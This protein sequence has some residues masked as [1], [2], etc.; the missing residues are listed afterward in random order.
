MSVLFVQ[1]CYYPFR[2]MTPGDTFD[3]PTELC[4]KPLSLVGLAGLDTQNNAVHKII[5]D[6]FSNNRRPDRAPVQFKLLDA[7]CE[8]APLK[9]KVMF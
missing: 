7:A 8:F 1:L 5:W 6:S 9:P 2:A 4:A 3:F